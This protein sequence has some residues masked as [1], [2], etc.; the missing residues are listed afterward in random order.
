MINIFHNLITLNNGR[1]V[2]K[3]GV[4]DLLYIILIGLNLIGEYYEVF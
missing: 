3:I 4:L 1:I 2:V